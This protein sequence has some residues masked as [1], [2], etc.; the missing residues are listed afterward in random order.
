MKHLFVLLLV[1]TA[2]AASAQPLQ[3]VSFRRVGDLN[4]EVF[5]F[6]AGQCNDSLTVQWTNTTALTFSSICSMNAMK[7]WSTAGECSN[8]PSADAVRY[9]DIPGATLQLNNRQGTFTV[10]L[11]ELPGF[12]GALTTDGGVVTCGATDI[13]RTHRLCG[14]I[15]YAQVGTGIGGTCGAS[16]TFTANSLKLVYDTLPPG[17]PSITEYGAQ[18][19]GVKVGFDV[20][21][22]TTVVQLEVKAMA[23]PDFR[24]IKESSA[25]SQTSIIGTGLI[26]NTTYDVR[27]RAVDAAGNVSLPSDAV[28]I[29]PIKTLGFYGYYRSL[30]GNDSGC[31]TG[32]GVIPALAAWLLVR[33]ARERRRNP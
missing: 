19:Q 24:V 27:L 29:T 5:T 9:D 3:A 13:L 30:G 11:A 28:A 7:V 10:K 8:T 15:D 25:T 6:G 18:D 26:N 33:R 31:S 1:G 16:T 4:N 23:D 2:L 21:S 14:A 32:W 12:S 22:D 17:A 20:D